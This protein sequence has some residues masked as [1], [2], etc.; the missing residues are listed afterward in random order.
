MQKKHAAET[1]GAGSS[2]V[3][4][5]AIAADLDEEDSLMDRCFA[6]GG[7]IWRRRR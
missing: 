4:G 6:Q 1:A 3:D 5:S 7:L 2:I